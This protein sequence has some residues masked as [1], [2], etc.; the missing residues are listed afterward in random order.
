MTRWSL[1]LPFLQAAPKAL[2][3][4]GAAE[5]GGGHSPAPGVRVRPEGGAEGREGAQP[6][7][8]LLRRASA[9]HFFVIASKLSPCG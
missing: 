8:D 1:D 7:A 2:G 6:P 9:P 5:G 3:V 4:G